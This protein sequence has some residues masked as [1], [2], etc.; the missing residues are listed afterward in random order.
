MRNV[1]TDNN[2]L[3][4]YLKTVEELKNHISIE[5]YKKEYRKLR[6]DSILFIKAQKFKS[7][8]TELRRLNSKK[9][10]LLDKFLDELN[11][12][13]QAS[14]F[15]SKNIDK[16]ETYSLYRRNLLEKSD[17]EIIALVIKQRTEAAMEFQR[18]VEQSLQ[19]L[20]QISSEFDSSSQKRR[21]MSL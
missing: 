19:Q 5:E 2:D 18:S 4:Q 11:P 6:A 21:K 8:H 7:A 13:N 9:E 3:I 16:L 17:E 14:A 20:S 15:A 1:K 12:V 10:S